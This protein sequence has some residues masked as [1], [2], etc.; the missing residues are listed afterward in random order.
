VREYHL[1]LYYAEIREAV[2]KI[3]EDANRLAEDPGNDR[4]QA[5]LNPKWNCTEGREMY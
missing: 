3:P 2:E 1:S 4:C 5:A